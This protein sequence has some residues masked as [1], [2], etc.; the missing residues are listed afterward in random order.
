MTRGDTR[1]L[2]VDDEP[3]MRNMLMA[4]LNHHGYK[5][6]AASNGAE[7]VEVAK[8]ESFHLVISDITMPKMDG[9]QLLEALQDMTPDTKV[10]LFSGVC[11]E[12][13]AQLAKEKGAA[14]FIHKP[15]ELAEL[16]ATVE[17]ILNVSPDEGEVHGA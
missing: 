6:A 10:I 9:F 8:K 12:D 1:V 4:I 16:T 13:R 5:T 14:E 2:I 3:N 7:A 11:T 17:R 15:F